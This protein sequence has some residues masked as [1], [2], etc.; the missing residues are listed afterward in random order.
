M[1]PYIMYSQFCKNPLIWQIV[2]FK[3]VKIT[4]YDCT[5]VN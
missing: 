3:D 1:N 2:H 5:L 4:E